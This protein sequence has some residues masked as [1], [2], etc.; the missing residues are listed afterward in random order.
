MIKV[1]AKGLLYT[2]HDP[3]TRWKILKGDRRRKGT[4][5]EFQVVFGIK[6][7]LDVSVLRSGHRSNR[8]ES[9]VLEKA[10]L[11]HF[12]QALHPLGTRIGYDSNIEMW[13]DESHKRWDIGCTT[14]GKNSPALIQPRTPL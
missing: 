2:L 10:P 14:S 13:T 4:V 3:V 9:L 12:E 1:T 11:G 5:D 7:I 6:E 8:D